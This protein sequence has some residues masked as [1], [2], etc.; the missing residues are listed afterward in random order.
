MLSGSS[1]LVENVAD[2][3]FDSGGGVHGA[4]K[5]EISR[6]ISCII[7]NALICLDDVME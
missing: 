5:S 2:D 3:G 1:L 4:I 7:P 6:Q